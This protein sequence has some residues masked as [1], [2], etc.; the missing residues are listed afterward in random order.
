M[1]EEQSL[2]SFAAF[3]DPHLAHAVRRKRRNTYG[4]AVSLKTG[5]EIYDEADKGNGSEKKRGRAVCFKPVPG[6]YEQR[7]RTRGESVCISW[8]AATFSRSCV[9]E[10]RNFGSDALRH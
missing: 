3:K 7:G 5:N 9:A 2:L 1:N 10:Y 6:E 4:G 8:V